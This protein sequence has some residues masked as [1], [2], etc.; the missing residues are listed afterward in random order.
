MRESQ[1]ARRTRA[2]EIVKR[3][4]QAYPDAACA[5]QHRNP[6]ELLVATILSAQCT[7]KMVNQVTPRLF[8]RFR[9]ARALADAPPAEIEHII[10]PTG[11]FRQKT[12]SIQAAARDIVERFGGTVPGTLEELVTLRG[13]GRKTANVVLGDAFG[14]PGLTVD[15]HMT[16]VNRRLGLTRNEDPVKIERDLMPLIPREE[17]T[18]Y[19]HRVIHHGRVCCEARR[20]QCA[21]CPVRALCPWPD[22][23]AARE[24]PT[25]EARR[26]GASG[27]RRKRRP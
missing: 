14:V 25:R 10:Q 13:V 26:S 23:R 6:F 19:S 5:L 2:S 17:W 4:Q 15:T 18:A 12:K 21:H 27:A 22:S 20:P 9:N 3:L 16:R 7:D 11:F 8:A 1:A 24:K